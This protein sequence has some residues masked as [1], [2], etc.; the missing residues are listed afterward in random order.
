VQVGGTAKTGTVRLGFAKMSTWVLI[1]TN[2]RV[3]RWPG[4]PKQER[5]G[6]GGWKCKNEGSK[7]WIC[8]NEHLGAQF[9][10]SKSW[11]IAGP[12]KAGHTKTRG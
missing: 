9:C 1:F 10:K 6:A 8:Q 3:G 7:A 2:P 4:L 11:E 12:A 5:R